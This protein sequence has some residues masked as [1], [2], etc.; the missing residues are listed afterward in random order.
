MLKPLTRIDQRERGRKETESVS[1]ED[2]SVLVGERARGVIRHTDFA[3]CS[4]KALSGQLRYP[5]FF[6]SAFAMT[7]FS[8]TPRCLRQAELLSGVALSREMSKRISA[9]TPHLSRA[10]C[11]AVV[12]VGNRADSRRYIGH[13]QRAAAACG[14]ELRVVDLPETIRQVEL[15]KA[16]AAVNGDVAVDAVILQLPLPPHLRARPALFHIHPGKDVDGLHPL[17]AGNLFLQDQSPLIYM[18]TNS[19]HQQ[20]H[21]SSSSAAATALGTPADRLASG[22]AEELML[23]HSHSG[24]YSA[25]RHR[26]HES[27]FFVPCTALAIRSLLFSYLSRRASLAHLQSA[28]DGDDVTQTST[29]T[30]AAE[31]YRTDAGVA[32]AAAT[33]AQERPT[34]KAHRDL[35]AVI[36]NKSM[37]VGVPTAALLQRAGGFLVTSCSR[38]N[39]LEAV[40]CIAKQADVL[41]TA[42]GQANVFDA[43]CVKAGAIVIDAAIN[44]LPT[45]SSDTGTSS[46]DGTKR[47]LSLCGDVDVASVSSVAAAVTKT[48]GGVGPLTVSHLMMNVLKAY[49]LRHANH[50]Y[51]NN[52]YT[53]FLKMYGTYDKV[54]DYAPSVALAVRS[55]APVPPLAVTAGG[56]A[57]ALVA[58]AEEKAL[59]GQQSGDGDGDGTD[60][61]GDVDDED[62]GNESYE[63]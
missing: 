9:V 42:Y 51:Y 15:H 30:S 11:L 18:L 13:K 22:L 60:E 58:A 45:P 35:H 57:A 1:Y 43:S 61:D 46:G 29:A 24:G 50:L 52:I 54:R 32:A 23:L 27:K 63:V 12:V 14:I 16:L 21:D 39:S 10:P 19:H 41:I 28:M 44:E 26:T 49:R 5:P 48:P 25:L 33:T 40:R 38:S 3:F 2:S 34:P 59:T 31:L 8:S 37:V 55:P 17:N 4:H 36:V 62:A 6:L 47:K 56:G 20:D 7:L 53:E